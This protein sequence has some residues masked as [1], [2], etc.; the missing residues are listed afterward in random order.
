MILPQA[1]ENADNG[2]YSSSDKSTFHGVAIGLAQRTSVEVVAANFRIGQVA[3]YTADDATNAAAHQTV[4]QPLALG[5]VGG[6][7]PPHFRGG[8]WESQIN[9]ACGALARTRRVRPAADESHRGE[10]GE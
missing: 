1:D 6:S 4:L 8:A 3:D 9:M 5:V 7:R 2:P 10:Q